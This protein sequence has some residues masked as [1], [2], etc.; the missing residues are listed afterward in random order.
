M[1]AP[2]PFLITP[3]ITPQSLCLP[4][5][6]KPTI[7]NAIALPS[8]EFSDI[9]GI[10]NRI[11]G[12]RRMSGKEMYEKMVAE[13]DWMVVAMR[14]RRQDADVI[15]EVASYVGLAGFPPSLPNR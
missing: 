4:S 2:F 7:Y 8:K 13:A 1:D 3:H 9:K 6:D 10:L 5:N 12:R 15:S 14:S 11:V